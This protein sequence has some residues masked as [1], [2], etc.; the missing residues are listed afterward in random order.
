[1]RGAEFNACRFPPP[2]WPQV[3]AESG[4][5]HYTQQRNNFQTASQATALST[6]HL[7]LLSIWRNVMRKT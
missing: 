1:M 4:S 7:E 6:V 5:A 3:L 2:G